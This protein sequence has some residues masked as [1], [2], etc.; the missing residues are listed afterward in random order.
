M[1]DAL[2]YIESRKQLYGPLFIDLVKKKERFK[3]LK[4]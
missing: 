3:E 1:K 4:E 2:G